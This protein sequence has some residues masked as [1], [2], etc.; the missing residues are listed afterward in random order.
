MILDIKAQVNYGNSIFK[1]KVENFQFLQTKMFFI[2]S[3]FQ[4]KV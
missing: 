2:K 1:M 3:S 4:K